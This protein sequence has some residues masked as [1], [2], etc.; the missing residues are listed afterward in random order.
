MCVCMYM[1]VYICVC[2]YV[3]VCV[4][5]CVCVYFFLCSK[6]VSGSM[7]YMLKRA[8]LQNPKC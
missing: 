5:V 4:C 6:L 1:C 3:C 8:T 2:V 7:F